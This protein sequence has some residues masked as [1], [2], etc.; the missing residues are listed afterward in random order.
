[1]SEERDRKP[2]RQRHTNIHIE[3][4]GE[5]EK[6]IDRLKDRDIYILR[7]TER[8]EDRETRRQRDRKTDRQRQTNIHI[9]IYKTLHPSSSPV[10]GFEPT[11]S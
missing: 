10:L 2:E 5:T 11:I 4:D 7:V 6:Q 3:R 1:M 8:Q 9:Y